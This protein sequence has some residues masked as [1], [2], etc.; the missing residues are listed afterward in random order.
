MGKKK[1]KK[2]KN[3]TIKVFVYGTLKE[4]GKLA[5]GLDGLRLS[6]ESATCKGRMYHNYRWPMIIPSTLSTDLITGE[7]HEYPKEALGIMDD[8]EGFIP[9]QANRSLFHRIKIPVFA[10]SNHTTKPEMIWAYVWPHSTINCRYIDEGVWDDNICV[11]SGFEL[12]PYEGEQ[13]PT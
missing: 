10:A 2:G 9:R 7:V 12:K 3:K 8:I 5:Q 4:G 11:E 6:N 1:G 13:S